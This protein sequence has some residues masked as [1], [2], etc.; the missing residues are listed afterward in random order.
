M[1]YAINYYTLNDQNIPLI[2]YIGL[3]LGIIADIYIYTLFFRAKEKS[4]V[5]Q[6]LKNVKIQYELE[7]EKLD[8][9]MKTEEEMCKIR[10]DYEN[11]CA[12]LKNLRGT[13]K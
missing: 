3:I 4:N 6:R 2:I 12:T 7:Q 10:H 9:L 5:E 11:Y 1:L 8:E 13:T